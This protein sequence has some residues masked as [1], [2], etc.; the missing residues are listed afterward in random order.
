MACQGATSGRRQATIW[1]RSWRRVPAA[2][3]LSAQA[4]RR[5]G[6]TR[7]TIRP[8]SILTRMRC[9]LGLRR[10]PAPRWNIWG[11]GEGQ[12]AARLFQRRA[13]GMVRVIT[14][15]ARTG[16][17]GGQAALAAVG[18]W[19]AYATHAGGMGGAPAAYRGGARPLRLLSGRGMRQRLSAGMPAEVGK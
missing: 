9:P 12:Y 1:R 17:S 11:S 4:I 5:V 19:P 14:R 7:P 8:A 6:L 2:T 10:S 13:R 16:V 3:S 18:L 15:L